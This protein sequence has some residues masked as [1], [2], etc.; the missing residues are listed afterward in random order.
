MAELMI[1]SKTTKKELEYAA[2]YY[3][4][5]GIMLR[6]NRNFPQKETNEIKYNLLC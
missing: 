2:N 3:R 4:E 5:K 1:F 6:L